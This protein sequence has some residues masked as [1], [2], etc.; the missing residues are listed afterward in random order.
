[1]LPWAIKTPG[2]PIPGYGRLL[3]AVLAARGVENPEG[4]LNPK[5]CGPLGNAGKAA[6][7]LR[8]S[9]K[10][11]IAG[12]YD[13]DGLCG[14]AILL[15]AL[16]KCRIPALVYI[17]ERDEGYGF[18]KNAVDTALSEE[19]DL[20]ITVDCGVSNQESIDYAVGKN[21]KVIVTDHHHF[22]QPPKNCLLVHPKTHENPHL[23]GAGV[24]YKITRAMEFP[25][26]PYVQLAAIA[27]M[28][29]AVQLTEGNRALVC[30]GLTQT[31]I[32]GI[33]AL[34]NVAG[35]DLTPETVCF[36]IAP[37]INAASRMGTPLTALHLL[38]LE[39][40]D[41][42]LAAELAS[43]LDQLNTERKSV[44]EKAVKVCE[45][46]PV[47]ML[48]TPAGVIG[49]IAAKLA[50]ELGVPATV[51][52]PKGKGSAR[53]PEGYSLVEM[54]KKCPSVLHYGGHDCAAGFKINPE[55]FD[56]F[57]SEFLKSCSVKPAYLKIDV[58]L[59]FVPSPEEVEELEKIGPFG[60]GNPEPLFF[61]RGK[62][63]VKVYKKCSHVNV[64]PLKGVIFG[65]DASWY[66]GKKVAVVGTLH[67]SDYSGNAESF[68]QDIR[69]DVHINRKLLV[70]MYREMSHK[71]PIPETQSYKL[72]LKVFQELG[73][74]SG[75]KKSL[76]SSKTYRRYALERS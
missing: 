26:Y 29:D 71:K 3:G 23:S 70:H 25:E 58:P 34:L 48:D 60:S 31:P 11:L 20:I 24:A 6:F 64:G 10:V 35:V 27:T 49:I 33:Q 50:D 55:K 16:E 56:V 21:I 57:K 36:Q 74:G 43:Q 30:K 15:R 68:I 2:Q 19:C 42:S 54:L 61:Y 72:A 9:R 46:Q 73:I 22:D 45:R 75:S 7:M 53:A 37:R 63:N 5:E 62:A 4:Y 47:V 28:A 14:A 66:D 44:V 1:M 67:V 59:G 18:H 52:T 40:D 51:I 65:K 41:S 17:P 76:F 12:D 8:S 69:P 13:C 39:E 32:P 38:L